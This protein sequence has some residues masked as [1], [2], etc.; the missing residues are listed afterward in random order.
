MSIKRVSPEE[1]KALIENEQYAYLDVRSIP[2]FDGGHPTGAY[3]IPIAHMTSSGMSPNPDFLAVVSSTFQ[4]D[5]RL[6]VGCQA[7][8]RSLRAAQVLINAG[9]EHVVDQRAGFEG[10]RNA[11]GQLEEAG[12]R[13]AGLSV[14][15]EA[16]EGRSYEE[17][18]Q[19]AVD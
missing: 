3:N 7:G 10:A 4:K 2:E 6:I 13:P 1:A 5:A 17:L 12:W 15:T 19:A 18:V 16:S 8:V 11:F 14:S 9:Y